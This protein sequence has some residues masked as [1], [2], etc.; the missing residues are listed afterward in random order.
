MPAG[1]GKVY[2]EPRSAPRN[3]CTSGSRRLAMRGI[4]FRTL[5]LSCATCNDVRMRS[6]AHGKAAVMG[7]DAYQGIRSEPRCALI[8]LWTVAAHLVGDVGGTVCLYLQL[9]G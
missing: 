7:R 5:Y 3:T 9:I 1:F 6:L 2:R 4:E 8:L